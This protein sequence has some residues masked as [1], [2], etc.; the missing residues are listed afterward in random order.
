MTK[1]QELA[2]LKMETEELERKVEDHEAINLHF[3]RMAQTLGKSPNRQLRWLVS[4]LHS[5]LMLLKAEKRLA[6]RCELAYLAWYG[7]RSFTKQPPTTSGEKPFNLF[8]LSRPTRVLPDDDD[9]KSYQ[10]DFS[11][12]ISSFLGQH[13]VQF[14]LLSL[15]G[16]TIH[17]WNK[18]GG[19]PGF[20][21]ECPTGEESL[22]WWLASLLTDQGH[23]LRRCLPCQKLHIANRTDKNFC[24]PKCRALN[25]MRHK[26][27]TPI[28]RYGKR[29]RPRKSDDLP[30]GTRR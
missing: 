21:L 25:N 4:F 29:G 15:A 7:N 28:D 9:L 19:K 30:K 3:K 18:P 5:D 14:N 27:K 22:Q 11:Q 10:K 23:R 13:H 12:K 16:S 17:V 1:D 20:Y 8:S 26:R 24:S 6:L 2:L